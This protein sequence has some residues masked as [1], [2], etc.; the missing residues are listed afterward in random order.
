MK[1]YC[2]KVFKCDTFYTYNFYSTLSRA[3]QILH[4]VLHNRFKK[5]KTESSSLPRFGGWSSCSIKVVWPALLPIICF[6]IWGWKCPDRRGHYSRHPL[7]R[8]IFASAISSGNDEALK[9]QNPKSSRKREEKTFYSRKGEEK[10]L[11]FLPL[12]LRLKDPL[13]RNIWNK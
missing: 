13:S 10:T 8:G 4:W 5:E 3:V 12:S 9:C 1:H 6:G 7:L 11:Y 2:C